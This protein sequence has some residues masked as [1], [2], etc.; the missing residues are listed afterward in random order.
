[1]FKKFKALVENQTGRNTKRFRTDNDLEFCELDFNKFCVVQ[2][3]ARHKALVRKPQQN[4]VA[5][6]INWTLL[7]RAR[8][9]HY[10]TGLWHRHIF[11]SRLFQQPVVL[12]IILHTSLLTS[13]PQ[14]KFG[15]IIPLTI[16]F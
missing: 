3:I 15:Q 14:N 8:C 13:K 9:I 11:E 16:L 10:N 5:E 4:D 1:M 12:Q 7:E 2:G 6:H